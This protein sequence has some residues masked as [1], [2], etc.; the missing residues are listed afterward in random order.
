VLAIDDDPIA[1]EL[2]RAVLEPIGCIVLAARSAEAG[3]A[4]ARA[5]LPDVVLLDLVMPEVDGFGVVE[6][7]NDDPATAAIPIVILTSKTLTA[8][9]ETS[10]RGRIAHVAQKGE[11]DRDALRTLIRRFTLAKTT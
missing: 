6:R 5:E 9:D 11:F 4:L 1:L 10:L 2:V 7:L 8:S 3:I